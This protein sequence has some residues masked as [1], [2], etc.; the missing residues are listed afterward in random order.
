MMRVSELIRD[1][2]ISS[3]DTDFEVLGVAHD[4]RQVEEGDLF[5][6]LAGEQ[7]D[8]RLFAEQASQRGAA[9]VLSSGDRPEGYTGHWLKAN[10]PRQVLGPLAARIHGHPDRELLMVG[11]TGTNGKS[12]VV[13]LVTSI[14]EAAG[15]PTATL[16]TLGYSFRDRSFP[17]ER[18]TPEATGLFR[19][20]RQARD[21]GAEAAAMEVSSHA[22]VQRRVGGVSFDLAVFTNLSRDHFDYHGDFERYFA[23]KRRLFDQLKDGGRAVVNVDDDYGRRLVHELEDVLSFGVEG[24]VRVLSAGLT[25]EGIEATLETPRGRLEV[26]SPLLGRYNLKNLTT[27]V[28]A[29]EAL[30]LSLDAITEG[31]ALC[32]TIPGRMEPVRRGQGFP[33]MIDYAHTDA[34]LAAALE[35]LREI[36]RQRVIVVFGCG[37]DR[38]K[39]KRQL[40]GEVAGRLADLPIVTSDNPRSEDPLEIIAAVEKGLQRS[41]NQAYRIIPDRAE[42][43]RYAINHAGSEW[44][45]L[46]AGKGHERVQIIGDRETTFSDREKIERVLE[47]QFGQGTNR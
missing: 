29:A 38:D 23:A 28:A 24:D 13:G 33:V 6:A 32:E 43:I 16:G 34:A 46:V 30:E 10:D 45:V 42:A 5:V 36:G 37:G 15:R 41:G 40:M 12:T 8:G 44:S 4:S 47:E 22:L 35:S 25:E 21:A 20:L 39:G 2:P 1:L 18:T 11:V 3:I 9:A 27:A 31:V 14:L 7:F 26:S 19:T 17:G